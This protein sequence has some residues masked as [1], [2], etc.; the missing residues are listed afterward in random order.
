MSEPS[1]P[2]D[3]V[4]TR[5]AALPSVLDFATGLF[6]HLP[7]PVAIFNATGHP[8][9]VNDAYRA[10]FRAE[11]PPEYCLLADEVAA[12]L[13]I[14]DALRRGFAGEVV[15]I[16]VF[17]YDPRQLE[18]IKVTDAR[19][20]AISCTLFPLQD[21]SGFVSHVAITYRD[22]TDT[23]EVQSRAEARTNAIANN[24]TMG[25]L[26]LNEQQQCVF[27]NPAAERIT[28]FTVEELKDGP[29]HEF[30]HHTRP[31]GT[32]Y[33]MS[34]CPIDRALP[35][36][37][38]EQGEDVFIRKD[39]TFYPVAFT[40]SPLIEDGRAVGTVVE[41]R[42]T[43]EEKRREREREELLADLRDAVHAREEFLSVASHE[44]KTPLTS[45]RLKIDMADR[46]LRRIPDAALSN[47]LL[48]VMD[49]ARKQAVRLSALVESLLDVSRIQAGKLTLEV[50]EFDLTALAGDVVQ[51]FEEHARR[52]RSPLR[53]VSPG[54]VVGVWDRIRVE[55]V[56]TNLL[57]NALKYGAGRPVELKVED[58]G[59]TVLIRVVDHGIGIEPEHLARIFERFE[60]AVSQRHYGGLGLGLY[61][62]R[63][64]VAALGGDLSAESAPGVHTAFTVTLPRRAR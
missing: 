9:L 19:P 36:R 4:R 8:Y 1:E 38:Q 12:R 27:M 31:D 17:H 41:M 55:Q 11:P 6:R 28:G 23:L 60:R 46:A 33:P 43:T 52:M 42:E 56:I 22:V 25:L 44:L 39:G 32:P 35:T 2:T 64:I 7:V 47:S 15:T 13:G 40:A 5:L 53:L 50:E 58:R 48:E 59:E 63:Q 54:P 24:A 34:E 57:D 51:R 21:P 20:V 29:L 14:Q 18:H 45:L 26:L 61:I 37:N 30:I 62:S 10:M 16:P 3:K 49:G